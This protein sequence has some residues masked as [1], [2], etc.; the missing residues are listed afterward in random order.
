MAYVGKSGRGN[1][2]R[3]PFGPVGNSWTVGCLCHDLKGE[4]WNGERNWWGLLYLF[5]RETVPSSGHRTLGSSYRAPSPTHSS[6]FLTYC[7]LWCYVAYTCVTYF[8]C[9]L[10]IAYILLLIP[11][12]KCQEGKNFCPLYLPCENQCLAVSRPSINICWMFNEWMKKDIPLFL[13][14]KMKEDGCSCSMLLLY[15]W[16]DV[17]VL[18]WWLFKVL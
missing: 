2:L 9:L 17:R 12:D 18:A 10:C 16:K 4:I 8:L 14:D 5:Y 7:R 11:T 3:I 1:C 6:Y 13:R 15:V